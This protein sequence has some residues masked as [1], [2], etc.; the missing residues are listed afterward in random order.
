MGCKFFRVL[1]QGLK[2]D[3]DEQKSDFCP[4]RDIAGGSVQ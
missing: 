2:G 3:S 1:I 4:H